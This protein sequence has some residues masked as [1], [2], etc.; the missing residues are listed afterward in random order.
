MSGAF[1]VVHGHFYQPPRE[2]PWLGIVERQDSARPFHDWNERIAA[3]CYTPNAFARMLDDEGRIVSIVNNYE[4]HV[5]STSARR[6]C[7]GSRSTR[8][9]TYARILDADARS[10]RRARP[11]QRHRAGAT[12]TPSCRCATSATAHA[13]PLGPRRLRA[14]LRPARRGACGCP[15]RRCRRRRAR[16]AP[17][18]GAHVRHPLAAPGRALRATAANGSTCRR[19]RSI[20][21]AL[22]PARAVGARDRRSSSTTGPSRATSAFEGCSSRRR[23]LVGRFASALVADRGREQL[24]HVATDGESYGH[25]TRLGDMHAGLRA[26]RRGAARAALPSPTTPPTSPR[27]RPS[28]RRGS[29]AGPTAKARPGAARTASAAGRAT[30]AATAGTPG[31][32]RRGARRSAARSTSCATAPAACTSAR[33]RRCLRD[34]WGARDRLRRASSLDA[35]AEAARSLPRRRARRADSSPTSG[36]ARCACCELQ[37]YAQLMYTS[38]GWFFDEH[39]RA[40]RPRRSCA[41]PTAP[42]AA[43]AARRRG[44]R[45]DVPGAPRR[46]ALQ[47]A[48]A[49]PT[50]PTST[51]AWWRRAASRTS[52]SRRRRRSC[53]CSCRARASSSTATIA[54][55]ASASAAPATRASG[56]S[57]AASTCRGSRRARSTSSPTPSS[58]S[59]PPTSACAVAPAAAAGREA[60]EAVWRQ[61]PGQSIARLVRAI[62]RGFGPAE[63]TMRDLLLEERHRVLGEVYGDLLKGVSEEYARL[64]DNHR[65]TMH[66]LD[67]AGLPIPEPLKQAAESVLGARFESEIARQRRSR[68]PARYRRAIKM[69]EDARERGLTLQRADAQ[70]AFA[71]TLC[72]LIGAIRTR[73]RAVGDRRGARLPRA[74][75]AP[76]ARGGVAARAG[77]LVGAARRA[78]GAHAR[79]GRARRRARLRRARRAAR[80]ARRRRR[81]RAR[82]RPGGYANTPCSSRSMIQRST[83]P[84]RSNA[85]G[86]SVRRSR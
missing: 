8:P 55:S 81:Q 21:R 27:T 54:S 47:P 32:T 83:R 11:R 84:K 64:Y 23:A 82:H 71:E 72:D 20:R 25:H 60:F 5:S 45:A 78:A 17:R 52:G 33:P 15:R 1:L 66:L 3:E 62:E 6:C 24:M 10:L 74:R 31:C 42:R 12:T 44:P 30:A 49:T 68:D 37:R 46:G 43:P 39:R 69:A 38:C 85:A 14:P 48:R 16:G 61:W 13:D 41:T 75:P 28:P 18:R 50:A 36:C 4:L 19:A 79:A 40:S 67:Q 29:R 35:R 76:R 58:T 51:A 57:P 77:D 2:N 53:R 34:P 56:S 7:R 26:R 63:Y 86:T 9:T 65:H 70:R 59:A 73:A 80:R 22:P